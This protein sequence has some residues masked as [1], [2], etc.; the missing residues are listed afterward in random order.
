MLVMENYSKTY[1]I[2]V[3]VTNS[4]DLKI[5]VFIGVTGNSFWESSNFVVSVVKLN[6][7]IRWIFR[8]EIL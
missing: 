7:V 8:E 4:K 5:T 1:R 2:T 3:P 6:I